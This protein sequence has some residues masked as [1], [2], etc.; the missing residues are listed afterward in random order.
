MVIAVLVAIA[1]FSVLMYANKGVLSILPYFEKP[2][3]YENSIILF[4]GDNCD[5][6]TKVDNFIRDNAM[7]NKVA[8]VRLN[9]SDNENLNLLSDKAQTCGLDIK[10]IGVPFLWDGKTCILGDVA[11]INFFKVQIAAKK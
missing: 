6:C 11:V 2:N 8:F 9:I 1:V 3:P 4:Y 7:E 10:L 5:H